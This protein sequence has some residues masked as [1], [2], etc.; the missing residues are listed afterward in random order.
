TVALAARPL[1]PRLTPAACRSALVNCTDAAHSVGVLWRAGAAM[2]H[3]KRFS[4]DPIISHM[5]DGIDAAVAAEVPFYHLILDGFFPADIYEE[6][7]D[8]LPTA[9]SFRAL[10]GRDNYNIRAD[11]SSTRVKIDLFPEY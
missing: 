11:G 7:L 8:H 6:M 3:V 9:E 5:V 2:R 4:P 10:P 1:A